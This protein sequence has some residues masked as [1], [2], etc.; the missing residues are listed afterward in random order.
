MSTEYEAWAEEEREELDQATMKGKPMTNYQAILLAFKK[1][2]QSEDENK[3]R[4]I[5]ALH[6]CRDLLCAFHRDFP[7]HYSD[8]TAKALERGYAALVEAEGKV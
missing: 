5:A 6:E 7:E 4:L 2:K 1:Q 8:K 3:A